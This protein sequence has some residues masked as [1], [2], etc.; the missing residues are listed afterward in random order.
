MSTEQTY[1]NL[2][3]LRRQAQL[4][5]RGTS[6]GFD[7]ATFHDRCDNK[8]ATL[9]VIERVYD[10]DGDGDID[11]DDEKHSRIFGAFTDIDWQS[12]D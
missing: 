4:L 1:S 6:D 9:T 3:S 7:A 12:E 10:A 8:G 2:R 11:S 5:Y